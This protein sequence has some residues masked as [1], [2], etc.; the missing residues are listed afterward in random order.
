MFVYISSIP[1]VSHAGPRQ[2]TDRG[3]RFAAENVGTSRSV[4]W[5]RAFHAVAISKDREECRADRFRRPPWSAGG[6]PWTALAAVLSIPATSSVLAPSRRLIRPRC[7]RVSLRK[8]VAIRASAASLM[9]LRAASVVSS[10]SPGGAG[11]SET[12]NDRARNRE[13]LGSI[14]EP[15]PRRS[16]EPLP[17]A[18][19]SEKSPDAAPAA[20]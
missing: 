18:E 13:R 20:T 4:Q 2:T 1:C 6:V 5:H 9:S 11:T 16:S 8:G 14:H 7:T 15:A 3:H 19:D 17:S 12:E 10:E